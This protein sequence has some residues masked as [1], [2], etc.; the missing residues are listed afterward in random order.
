MGAGAGVEHDK[1]EGALCP[2]PFLGWDQ[3]FK[4]PWCSEGGRTREDSEPRG[5]PHADVTFP[6]SR[7]V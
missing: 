2:V 7:L 3:P 6:T 5:A 1:Q 4:S